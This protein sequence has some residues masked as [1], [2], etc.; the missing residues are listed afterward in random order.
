MAD[1]GQGTILIVDDD[2]DALALASRVVASAGYTVYRAEDAAACMQALNTHH[3]D[4]LLLDVVLPDKDGI[5]LCQEIKSS[6]RYPDTFVILLSSVRKDSD[7]QALGLESGADGYIAR[8]VTNREL[9][10][11]VANLCRLRRAEIELRSERLWLHR[12]LTSIGD[13][14]L[15][16][17]NKGNVL[18]LNPVAERLTGWTSEDALGRPSEE[19][20]RLIHVESGK[21]ADSPVREVLSACVPIQLETN[22]QLVGRHGRKIPI[23]DSVAP[24]MDEGRCTGAVVVFQDI[25][26]RVRMEAENVQLEASLRQSQKLEAIGLLASGVAHEI[27]NPLMGV[28][29]FAELLQTRV[30]DP[31]Q[32]EFVDGILEETKRIASIVKGLLL[33]SRQDDAEFEYASPEYI[34]SDALLLVRTLLLR[35]GIEVESSCG[36]RLPVIRCRPVQIQQIIVNLLINARD[37]INA[38]TPEKSPS[39]SIAL[40]ANKLVDKEGAWVRILVE[41]TGIGIPEDMLAKVFDPFFTTKPRHVGT[42]LGLS[43]CHGIAE[44]HGARL[45]LDSAPDRG[46]S[47]RLDLR[48]DP[49]MEDA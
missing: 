2:A 22:L 6:G 19:V 45:A 37:A 13:G 7:S 23:A 39:K 46:T 32:A 15:A 47:V 9:L 25:S 14:V 36:E 40:S 33:F 44:E 4:L 16:T 18:F 31:E 48:F 43:I 11:R 20:L 35:D 24:I 17:D 29:G 10:A 34:I 28:M 8:P 42:G 27:N 30:K 1:S 21:T 5:T 3:P 38:K 12:M 49:S 26:E 41:D